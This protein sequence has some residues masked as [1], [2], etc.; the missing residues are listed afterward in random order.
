MEAQPD[1]KSDLVYEALVSR[2]LFTEGHI[3]ALL[4]SATVVV[5]HHI[6]ESHNYSGQA[7]ITPT[8]CFTI[9]G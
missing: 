9:L 4:N 5:Q 1:L 6:A 3:K 2:L 8:G 7:G